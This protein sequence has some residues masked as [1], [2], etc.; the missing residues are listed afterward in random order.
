MEIG[1]ADY[2]TLT[3]S[4]IAADVQVE[5]DISE[6]LVTWRSGAGE[7]ELVSATPNGDGT[8]TFVYRSATPIPPTARQYV[9]LR[10]TLR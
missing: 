8:S 4:A 2:L 1:G 7:V 3:Y 5:I 6:D 9:R 10:L